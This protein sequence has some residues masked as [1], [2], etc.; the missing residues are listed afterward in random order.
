MAKQSLHKEQN[1]IHFAKITNVST[2]NLAYDTA[3]FQCL[4]ELQTKILGDRLDILQ[5]TLN[6]TI[7]DGSLKLLKVDQLSKT[8]E[9]EEALQI[10]E[11]KIMKLVSKLDKFSS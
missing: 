6:F 10:C 9:S 2:N 4:Q 11:A 1:G 7:K 3:D 8:F 5:N